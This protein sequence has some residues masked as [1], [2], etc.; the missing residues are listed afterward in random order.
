RASSFVIDSGFVIR[1]SSLC[2]WQMFAQSAMRICSSCNTAAHAFIRNLAKA[3]AG[4]A[5]SGGGAFSA[6]VAPAV[7]FRAAIPQDA[8]ACASTSSHVLRNP[9]HT[10]LLGL[11]CPGGL[12]SCCY[13]QDD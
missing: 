7:H 13:R 9:H 12:L 4:D 2:L 3:T 6:R 8:Q 11:A 5:P 1:I 10:E